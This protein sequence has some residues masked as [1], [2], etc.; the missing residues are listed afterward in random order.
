MFDGMQCSNVENK[1]LNL[2]IGLMH[3]TQ[4]SH[5]QMPSFADIALRSA[6]RGYPGVGGGQP[7]Q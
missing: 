2:T 1:M 7:D 3:V 5:L 6:T 4:S